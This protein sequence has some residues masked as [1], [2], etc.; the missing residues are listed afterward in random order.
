[1]NN[2]RKLVEKA[3]PDDAKE[4]L[5]KF[6]ALQSKYDNIINQKEEELITLI[7]GDKLKLFE[8]AEAIEAK[9]GYVADIATLIEWGIRL[10]ACASPPAIGCLWNLAIEALK[11]IFAKLIQ[12]CWFTKE[13][14]APVINKVNL[15]KEFPSTLASELVT[16]LNGYVPVPEGL[17]PWFAPIKVNLNEFKMDC[18]DA[19]DGSAGLTAER[20]AIMDIVKEDGGDEKLKAAL[21][22]MMKRG[23]G[24]W[25]LL[26]K[27]RLAKLLQALETTDV[28]A[29]QDAAKDREKPVPTGMGELMGD[30]GKYTGAE[31]KLIA[32]AKAAQERKAGLAALT[33]EVEEILNDPKAKEALAKAYPSS[34]DLKKDL[35]KAPWDTL[36]A[37]NG[38]FV[39]VNG[40]A[41]IILKTESGARIGGY[42]KY[43]D[44]DAK[45]PK[46]NMIVEIS[47]FYAVDACTKRG[48]CYVQHRG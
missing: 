29:M 38:D 46:G 20:K 48:Q 47:Q 33:K 9:I 32:E 40:H 24:P 11:W 5:E 42:F 25:V 6:C 30:I 19:A 37:G 23:A 34:E 13:V 22:L 39:K 16:T 4:Y 45:E 44:R 43:Y 14:Y 41:L 8:A 28:K 12:T 10:I 15:V 7:F 27:D 21:E 31:K 2:V 1:M 36:S 3:L 17:D 35:S 26:D 18:N